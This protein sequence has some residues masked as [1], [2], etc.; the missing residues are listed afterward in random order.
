MLI[1]SRRTI[2]L[3]DFLEGHSCSKQ[4]PLSPHLYHTLHACHT[5]M[6]HLICQHSRS[7]MFYHQSCLTTFATQQIVV[8][9]VVPSLNCIYRTNQDI[10]CSF[11]LNNHWWVHTS[12][13]A[14]IDCTGM[15][16]ATHRRCCH[17]NNR[18]VMARCLPDLDCLQQHV[19]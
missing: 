5:Y 12:R 18:L 11:P 9:P 6:D 10:D 4:E 1:S 7:K 16:R 3:E 8:A 14:S 19:S 15:C 2:Q 17:R 13:I